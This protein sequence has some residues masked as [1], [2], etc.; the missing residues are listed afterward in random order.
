M[1]RSLPQHV[2]QMTAKHAAIRVQLIDHD[3]SQILK[4]PRPPRV[5]RQNPGVQHVGIRQDEMSLFADGFAR[6]ARCVAVVRENTESIFEAAIQIVQFGE[7]ILRERLRRKK[8]NRARVA[9]FEDRVQHRQ[10]VA[11]RF[12]R[13]GRSHDDDVF[14]GV[15]GLGRRSLMRVRLANAL[16]FICRHEIGMNPGREFRKLRLA[17]WKATDRR[18]DLPGR[19]AL[20]KAIHDAESARR[21][22]R[23]RF[24]CARNG[25]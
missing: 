16:R 6:V 12:A 3:V 1:R 11:E 20:N 24:W 2:A 8:I 10:V 21:G 14:A 18:D 9:V 22:R 25:K 5:M 19:V 7:L 15:Y 23:Q 4:Q 13:S 17:R